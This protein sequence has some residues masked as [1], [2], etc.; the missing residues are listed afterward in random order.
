MVLEVSLKELWAEVSNPA[1]VIRG[2]DLEIV[3]LS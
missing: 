2:A 3:F 1:Y